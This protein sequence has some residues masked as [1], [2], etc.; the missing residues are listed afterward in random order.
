M[1]SPLPAELSSPWTEEAMLLRENRLE[2][3]DPTGEGEARENERDFGIVRT[4]VGELGEG[5]LLRLPT[6]LEAGVPSR[7][8][9]KLELRIRHGSSSSVGMPVAE[10]VVVQVLVDMRRIKLGGKLRRIFFGN[11]EG[12]SPVYGL[13]SL[14]EL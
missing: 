12:L 6:G 9:R 8:W 10:V 14:S 4:T 11:M 2:W 13:S 1:L 7:E 3:L 5:L